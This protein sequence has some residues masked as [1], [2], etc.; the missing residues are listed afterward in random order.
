MGHRSV[1]SQ[2]TNRSSLSRQS[3]RA[4]VTPRSKSLKH[5][6][7]PEDGADEVG[8]L[9]EYLYA[10]D[11]GST[12]SEKD[13]LVDELASMYI[14]AEKYQLEHLK[15]L[16]VCKI[17]DK[18]P[19][20][21]TFFTVGHRIY[22]NTPE[23]DQTFKKYSLDKAPTCIAY[24]GKSGADR[25]RELMLPGG[26]FAADVFQAQ[27]QAFAISQAKKELAEQP[28]REMESSCNAKEASYERMKTEQYHW[29]SRCGNCF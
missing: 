27:G 17:Q 9:L 8:R 19:I 4:F 28:L 29:H 10:R 7:L 26:L 25:V 20:P 16:T 22:E 5:I 13:I 3:S 11:Y 15:T 2:P 12:D 18:N 23:S 21:E 24:M 1:P 14:L 6:D